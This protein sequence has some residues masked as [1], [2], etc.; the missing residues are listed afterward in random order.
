[1]GYDF[2]SFYPVVCYINGLDME[3]VCQDMRLSWDSSCY[4]GLT[5][6]INVINKYETLDLMQAWI[7]QC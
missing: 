6:E 1:M 7:Q 2:V 3:F 5:P 4:I